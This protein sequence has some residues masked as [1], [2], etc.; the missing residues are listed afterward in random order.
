MTDHEHLRLGS[1]A[2]Y[3]R[4]ARPS[5][6]IAAWHPMKPTQVRSTAGLSARRS[7][8]A[9][10]PRR[11]ESGARDQEEVR[12]V[13]QIVVEVERGRE[14]KIGGA[15][16]DSAH[17]RAGVG[18]DAPREAVGVVELVG[19]PRRQD[20]MPPL[21]AAALNHALEQASIAMALKHRRRIGREQAVHLVGRDRGPDRVQKAPI[22][23]LAWWSMASEGGN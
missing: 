4:P 6:L 17:A 18:E 13:L 21:D 23:L 5:A 22:S 14:R 10:R 9:S 16:A 8:S 7:I 11:R 3:V 2:Y 1:G 20:R 12:D 15:L 19:P